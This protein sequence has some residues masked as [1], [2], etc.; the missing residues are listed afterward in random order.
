VS[1]QVAVPLHARVRQVV[2]VHVTVEPLHVPPLQA[3]LYVQA[4]PSSQLDVVRHAHVP[5]AL[6]HT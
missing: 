6:L 4:L 5:P 3:S 2:L 1:V